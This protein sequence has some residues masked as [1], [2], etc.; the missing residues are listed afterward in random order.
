MPAFPRDAARHVVEIGL[1]EDLGSRGDI[2]TRALAEGR[3][4]VGRV[5]AREAAVVAGLPLGPIVLDELER[6]GYGRAACR[7]LVREGEEARPGRALLEVEGAATAILAGERLL[8]NLLARLCGIATLTRRAVAEIE[9]TGAEIADTRKT[10]PGLRALE[11]YAVAVGGGRNHRFALDEL[12][13]IKDN[14]KVLCGGAAAAVRAAVRAGHEPS[15]IEL[16]A[17]DLAE[18]EEGLAAGCGWILLDNMDPGTVREAVRRT[19]GRARLEVSGGLRPG[20][21]RAFAEAGVDRLSLG[22]LTHGA[23]AVDLSLDLIAAP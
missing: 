18:L 23:P 4:A 6:R 11:K 10:T 14:H 16:E 13:L 15:E 19:A 5:M 17:D 1:D 21:L 8:L 12:V 2:T 7:A 9:G 20:R 3:S 22:C